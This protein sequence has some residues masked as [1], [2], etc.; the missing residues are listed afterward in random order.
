M[1]S[2]SFYTLNNV[3]EESRYGIRF[4]MNDGTAYKK[5]DCKKFECKILEKNLFEQLLTKLLME[6]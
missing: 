3:G 2:Y 5:P 6:K 1:P 4:I